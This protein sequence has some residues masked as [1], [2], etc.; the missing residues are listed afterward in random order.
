[1]AHANPLVTVQPEKPRIDQF[2]KRHQ[3]VHNG[4]SPNFEKLLFYEKTTCIAQILHSLSY[5]AC[6]ITLPKLSK[7]GLSFQIL[8]TA[9]IMDQKACCC[10]VMTSETGLYIPTVHN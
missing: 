10:N 2:T 6:S 8:G 7:F 9:A 5:K 3:V 1:M 4:G